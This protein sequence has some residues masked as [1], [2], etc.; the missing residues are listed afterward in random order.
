MLLIGRRRT[1]IPA[2]TGSASAKMILM[3]VVKHFYNRSA[4]SADCKPVQRENRNKNISNGL[5]ISTNISKYFN[6]LIQIIELYNL[7]VSNYVSRVPINC[8]VSQPFQSQN[9]WRI[10]EWLRDSCRQRAFGINE[11]KQSYQHHISSFFKR[12][13]KRRI[14]MDPTESLVPKIT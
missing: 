10:T 2:A 8:K 14:K 6:L 9:V 1:S 11:E 5:N 12:V 4:C 7:T 13:D 3:M